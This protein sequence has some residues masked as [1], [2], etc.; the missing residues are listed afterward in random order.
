MNDPICEGLS[1]KSG[2]MS[3]DVCYSH[4]NQSSS[5]IS[6]KGIIKPSN[7]ETY[8]FFQFYK[9]IGC[10]KKFADKWIL[11]KSPKN[12]PYYCSS[13]VWGYKWSDKPK[14]NLGSEGKILFN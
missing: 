1:F 14:Y 12:E 4:L 10:E 6:I 3:F 9:E 13:D 2:K 8:A 11:D 5:K 7:K